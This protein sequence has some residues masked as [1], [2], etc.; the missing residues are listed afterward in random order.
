MSRYMSCYMCTCID[1]CLFEH[2]DEC[3]CEDEALLGSRDSHVEEV[4]LLSQVAIQLNTGRGW[5]W[6][7]K[8]I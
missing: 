1:L 7:H 5:S 2:P 4:P 6:G 8:D 3:G